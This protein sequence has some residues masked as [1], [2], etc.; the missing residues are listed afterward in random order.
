MVEVPVPKVTDEGDVILR[1]TTTAICGSDLHFY[2]GAMPGMK[3]G[4]IVGHGELW[5]IQSL[6]TSVAHRRG[7]RQTIPST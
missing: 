3:K 2:N 4:D 6:H 5:C 7:L 1:V